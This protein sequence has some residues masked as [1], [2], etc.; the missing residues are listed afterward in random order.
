[1]VLILRTNWVNRYVHTNCGTCTVIQYICIEYRYIVSHCMWLAAWVPLVTIRH[2]TATSQKRQLTH[3]HTPSHTLTHTYYLTS[4][5]GECKLDG[6]TA[7]TTEGIY[8][9]ITPAPLSNVLGNLFRSCTEPAL[10]VHVWCVG[11]WVHIIRRPFPFL[12][13]KASLTQCSYTAAALQLSGITA[14]VLLSVNLPPVYKTSTGHRV[15]RWTSGHCMCS[16]Y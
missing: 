13:G 4:L 10:C 16:K 9:Q 15:W 1:M 2:N 6:I 14:T 7:N 11:I 8:H 5:T 12:K 3:P